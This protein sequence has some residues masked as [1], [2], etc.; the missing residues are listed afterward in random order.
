V[1]V[2]NAPVR[3]SLDIDALKNKSAGALPFA[4]AI[5]NVMAPEFPV[6]S[7]HS[8]AQPTLETVQSQVNRLRPKSLRMQLRFLHTLIFALWLFGRLI[9]WQ[10]YVAKYF[11][12][13]VQNNNIKRW[14]KYAH[15]FRNFAIE[16]GGVMIKAGQFAST[17][18]DIL[19]E[20][21]IAEL[22]DLQDKV[23]TIPYEQIQAVLKRE[24]GNLDT[25]YT[26]INPQPIAAASLGQVH[27][28]QLKNGDKVVIKVQ[29]PNVR[30][31]VYT[32]MAALF[33]VGKVAMRF[34]FIRRRA[35][36][37]LLIE[38]FGRVLLEEVSYR[39]EV[40]NAQRFHKM[41]DDNPGVYVPAIYHEHSTDQVITIEDVTSV[42]LDD[43]AALARY[44][45][46]RKEVAKRLMDTYM[47]QIFEERFFH[48]DPHPGNL[49]VYPL[50]VENE[51][52]YVQKGGGRP[53]YLIFIDFGMTG[54]LSKE[55]VQALI[56]TLS[57]VITRDAKK[58]VASY[59]DLGF[60]LPNADVHRIEEATEAVF[61]EV[62]GLSMTEMTS[63]DFDRVANIGKEFSDLL[64]EM[65][66]RIP[67]DFIYL[68]RTVSILS[69]MSTALDPQFNPWTTIQENVQ[70]LVTSDEDN[71]IFKELFSI[72][73]DPI[74]QLLAGNSQGFLLS[75]QRLWARLQRPNKSEEM[76]RQIIS[77]EVQIETKLSPFNRKQLERLE[78]QGKRTTR[79]FIAGSL[80]ISS[81][82][83]YTNGDAQLATYGYVATAITFVWMLIAK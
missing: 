28:A 27:K 57:A 12:R 61:D 29:R 50:P 55:L 38:E 58:L 24:L 75:L 48:A 21:V 46:D 16:M 54:T 79:A 5:P 65:P 41:F 73:S 59:Q 62:W 52:E 26:S 49:F 11:P 67:Q 17:R 42:K 76:L 81:T 15:Q 4:S 20:A 44:G 78:V 71:N 53:F 33:I 2:P 47:H 64:F 19:P 32:D 36:M 80:L 35:D 37:V 34:S 23:P 31:I 51:Q 10:V 18:A 43:Y 9:A 68:G 77:G 72:V 25:R 13:W 14:R 56:N 82:L 7:P 66:F 1:V 83:F 69:G 39:K 63:M 60:L 45:I 40:E 6:T 8:D 74:Q 22:V 30:D 70:H 3:K